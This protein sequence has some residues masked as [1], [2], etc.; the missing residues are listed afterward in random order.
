MR[1]LVVAIQGRHPVR[2]GRARTVARLSVERVPVVDDWV[3]WRRWGH[4]GRCRGMA[5]RVGD[6][7]SPPLELVH[8]SEEVGDGAS[9]AGD[10][11][12]LLQDLLLEVADPLLQGQLV[13][14]QHVLFVR[15]SLLLTGAC[16][17][18]GVLKADLLVA[19]NPHDRRR[20]VKTSDKNSRRR[21]H[22]LGGV[23]EYTLQS[24][25]PGRRS[26]LMTLRHKATHTTVSNVVCGALK[27]DHGNNAGFKTLTQI[28]GSPTL[29]ES[30][31]SQHCQV[32]NALKCFSDDLQRSQHCSP[33]R[34]LG[35]RRPC[36]AI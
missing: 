19:V 35:D 31:P 11:V 29:L 32:P 1:R 18:T 5:V 8:A 26:E 23:Y 15:R 12:R 16:F 2:V 27:S 3:L 4:L 21:T 34:E 24:T 14:V 9:Q 36:S 10:L 6:H 13:M 20:D 30:N 22:F 7:R 25:L 28:T 33:T 17:I